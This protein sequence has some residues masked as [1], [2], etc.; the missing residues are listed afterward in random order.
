MDRTSILHASIRGGRGVY[1][2]GMPNSIF[3]EIIPGNPI[4]DIAHSVR[5]VQDDSIGR[6]G[7]AR[8][9]LAMEVVNKCTWSPGNDTLL[10]NNNTF[11]P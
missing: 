7:I 3:T 2:V 11:Y 9:S 10:E 8:A 1:K 5:Y 6:H 4:I